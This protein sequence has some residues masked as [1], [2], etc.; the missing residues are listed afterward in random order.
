MSCCG[1]EDESEAVG[2]VA[3]NGVGWQRALAPGIGSA[4]AM[5]IP[6]NVDADAASTGHLVGV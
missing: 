4:D 2:A 6:V 1:R 3:V 5:D